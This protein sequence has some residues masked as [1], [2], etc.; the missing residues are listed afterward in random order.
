MDSAQFKTF[1]DDWKKR[2][3]LDFTRKSHYEQ[4]APLFEAHAEVVEVTAADFHD[5]GSGTSYPK[6]E[7]TDK[8]GAAAGLSFASV[9][10]G[11]RKDSPLC[12]VGKA[13]C[14]MLGPDGQMI[15]LA[16]AEYEYDAEVRAEEEILKNQMK[17][18]TGSKYADGA[19]TA[20][21]E[22]KSCYLQHRKVARRRADTG[23]RC[24]AII[25]ALG[26]PTGMKNLFAKSPTVYFLFSRI[27]YNAK[28]KMVMDRALDSMFGAAKLLG[29]PAESGDAVIPVEGDDFEPEL[30]TVEPLGDSP[31]DLATQASADD[32]EGVDEAF[33]TPPQSILDELSKDLT[34]R[35]S[36][37]YIRVKHENKL[38]G[39]VKDI[40]DRYL[41]D[42]ASTDEQF[43]DLY[44][45]AK[46][47]LGKQ[48]IEI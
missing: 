13:Q 40:I 21:L 38:S 17:Y 1:T 43:Y 34:P 41:E 33:G 6:K 42:K 45:K 48:G 20:E 18:K 4:M 25:A 22:K 16:P 27:I 2:G 24:A 11:T 9:N 19:A 3:A 46:D 12:F 7:T 36:L 10:I 28:N 23:A 44:G 26:M 39:K 47:Y 29:G 8:F 14:R 5:L 37:K 32:Y 30:R 31:A 15:D 35:G